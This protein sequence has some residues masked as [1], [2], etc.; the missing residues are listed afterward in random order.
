MQKTADKTSPKKGKTQVLDDSNIDKAFYNGLRF[1][2]KS[3]VE[4]MIGVEIPDN[5]TKTGY[6]L[7]NAHKGVLI[8][9]VKY[10][11][12][13]LYKRETPNGEVYG[14]TNVLRSLEFD[15]EILTRNRLLEVVQKRNKAVRFTWAYDDSKHDVALVN[16][17][18]DSYI[19]AIKMKG[20]TVVP[21][22]IEAPLPHNAKDVSYTLDKHLKLSDV[23]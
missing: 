9:K 19:A 10:N 16:D 21:M 17:M 12:A 14:D 8:D 6:L 5:L 23:L 7:K 4:Q 2:I 1:P 18:G 3:F 22:K 20:K 15:C 11:T 13:G